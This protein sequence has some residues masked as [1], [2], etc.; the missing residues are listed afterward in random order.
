MSSSAV[1]DDKDLEVTTGYIDL[2]SSDEGGSSAR[3]YFEDTG[4][5]GPA[6]IFIYGLGCSIFHWKHQLSYFAKTKHRILWLDYRGHGKSPALVLGTRLRMEM[7]EADIAALC[8][9]RG[10]AAATLLGQSMGGTLALRFAYR[11]PGLVRG[12]VLL[13]APP[14][15]PS[16]TL[17][18]G[19]IGGVAWQA[20]IALNKSSPST[21]RIGMLGIRRLMTPMRELVRVMGFNPYLANTA[22]IEQYVEELLKTDPNLFWDLAADL[23]GLEIEKI[24][25]EIKCPTLVIAGARDQ[26]VPLD[27]SVWLAKRIPS[28][29]LEMVQHGSHCPHFDD[30][31]LVNRRIE[32]FLKTHAL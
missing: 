6:L 3:I 31:P 13:A 25:P 5:D 17:K 1:F 14:R 22:D 20:A 18:L 28:A 7:L 11:N 21:M 8:L 10:I 27:H 4:G 19:T 9:V 15:P 24:T 26:V 23:E 30:P 2:P 12:L 16:Q 29:E 32:R